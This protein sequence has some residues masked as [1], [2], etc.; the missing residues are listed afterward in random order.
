MIRISHTALRAVE[1]DMSDGS[2]IRIAEK[3]W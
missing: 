3:Y 1:S 2:L